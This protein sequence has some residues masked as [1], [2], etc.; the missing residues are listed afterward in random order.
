MTATGTFGMSDE[1]AHRVLAVPVDARAVKAPEDLLEVTAELDQLGEARQHAGRIHVADAAA[2]RHR[3]AEG[4]WIAVAL[5]LRHR[6]IEA[7]RR[8][9]PMMKA[10]AAPLDHLAVHRWRIVVGLDQLHVHV[11]GKAHREPHIRTRGLAAIH[12]IDAGEML[13]HEPWADPEL[14]DPLADRRVEIRHDVG[15]LDDAVVGLT[16]SHLAHN[17]SAAAPLR[18]PALHF[19]CRGLQRE[20]PT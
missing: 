1:G 10:I 20:D 8:N 3:G 15:H 14:R 16:K 18:T 19:T 9:A 13:Q 5:I 12:R 6:R 2:A 7:P 4:E 11:P 17:A